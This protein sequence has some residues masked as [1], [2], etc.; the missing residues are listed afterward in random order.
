VLIEDTEEDEERAL[1]HLQK[2]FD[3]RESFITVDQNPTASRSNTL[4]PD[5]SIALEKLN[6]SVCLLQSIIAVLDPQRRSLSPLPVIDPRSLDQSIRHTNEAFQKIIDDM[7]K[8][9]A[10]EA[11]AKGLIQ[12]TGKGMKR[13]CSCLAP[14]LKVFLAVGEKGSSVLLI[15]LPRTYH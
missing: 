12:T 4:D 1:Q 15:P 10:T 7:E 9:K 3:E 2:T 5:T 8:E 6:R 11:A 14:F 13:V